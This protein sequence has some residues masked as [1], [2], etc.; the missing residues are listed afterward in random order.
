MSQ[1]DMPRKLTDIPVCHPE[2]QPKDLLFESS[3]KQILHRPLRGHPAQDERSYFSS[4]FVRPAAVASNDS[5][6][7]SRSRANAARCAGEIGSPPVRLSAD[8]GSRWTPLT[9]T[10]KWRCGPVLSPVLPT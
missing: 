1:G 6:Y 8:R 4:S 3:H 2:A 9:K 5:M 7:R 10:S